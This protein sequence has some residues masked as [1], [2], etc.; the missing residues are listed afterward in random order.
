MRVTLILVLGTALIGGA[1]L[2]QT[3]SPNSD[4]TNNPA[5]NSAASSPTTAAPTQPQPQGHPGPIDTT[6]GGTPASS[7]QGDL[8]PGMQPQPNDRKEHVTPKK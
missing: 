4:P 5:A 8:P 7:L 3:A 1:A 6:S 2:A